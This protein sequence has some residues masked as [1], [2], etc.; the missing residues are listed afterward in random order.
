M[1]I[2]R[3]SRADV[4]LSKIDWSRLEGVDDATIEAQIIGDPETAPI[5]TSEELARA[6]RVIA[7]EPDAV[8]RALAK[9]RR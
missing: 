5:F 4:D 2:V 8:I 9:T 7:S 6:R 1:T 3:R